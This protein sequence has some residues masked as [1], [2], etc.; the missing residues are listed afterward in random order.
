MPAFFLQFHTRYGHDVIP[1][2]TRNSLRLQLETLK[3]EEGVSLRAFS[4]KEFAG[5]GMNG[6]SRWYRPRNKKDISM[7]YV[8]TVRT[9]EHIGM[10]ERVGIGDP[11]IGRHIDSF[12][13]IGDERPAKTLKEGLRGLY[14]CAYTGLGYVESSVKENV[15]KAEQGTTPLEKYEYLD[16]AIV[17]EYCKGPLADQK[18]LDD[19]CA[20]FRAVD[21]FAA[22]FGAL[23]LL[24]NSAKVLRGQ[25]HLLL[26]EFGFR[27]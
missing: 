16:R 22:D 18:V 5:N 12:V 14:T 13:I 10:R 3:E 4:E 7:A 25:F 8:N 2:E 21:K 20:Q 26:D 15:K 24:A 6:V 9:H 17:L 1:R 11:T 19:L 23:D 27:E